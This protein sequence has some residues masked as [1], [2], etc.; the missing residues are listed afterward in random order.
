MPC[1]S[2]AAASSALT[3][4]GTFTALAALTATRSAQLPGAAAHATR[5]PSASPSTPSPT[6]TT[7]PAPSAPATS[8]GSLA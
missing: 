4:S 2:A 3:P 8:G 6:A 5:S 7:V 1:S